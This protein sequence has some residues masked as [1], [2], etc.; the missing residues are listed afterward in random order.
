MFMAAETEAEGPSLEQYRDYLLLLTRLQFDPRLQGKLDPADLVQQTLRKAHRAREQLRGQQQA[1]VVAWLRRI[2]A[3]TLTDALRQF[4]AEA[5]DLDRERSL[6]AVLAESSAR[7]EAWLAG[8]QSTPSQQAMRNEQL[9]RL[10]SALAQLPDDQRMAVELKH[11]QGLPV[12]AVGQRMGR[13][14]AAVVGL[15]FRGLKKLRELLA[16][17]S[18]G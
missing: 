4:H 10:A 16:E 18:A 5:R 3:N 6:E 2:L 1:E 8:E 14:R 11:L 7:I 13:S 15:L 12:A 9:Q 17:P